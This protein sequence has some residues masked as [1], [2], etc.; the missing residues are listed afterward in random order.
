MASPVESSGLSDDAPSPDPQAAPENLFGAALNR[1]SRFSEYA[2]DRSPDDLIFH[3]SMPDGR[4]P[5][6]LYGADLTMIVRA[7]I[8]WREL[9]PILEGGLARASRDA[10][11][12]VG[13]LLDRYRAIGESER[14]RIL[15]SLDGARLHGEDVEHLAYLL[16]YIDAVAKRNPVAAG[17]ARVTP[18]DE[19]VLWR[20]QEIDRDLPEGALVSD[21]IAPARRIWP[22]ITAPEVERCVMA[23]EI[24][25]MRT[26]TL[27]GGH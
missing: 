1:V 15:S 2:R 11:E 24:S 18:F 17:A 14:P 20:F 19:W 21:F 12:R 22:N 27:L 7:A 13:E 8:A 10:L 23:L 9:A 16:D 3:H 6:Q 25:K 26:G 4:P 5:V